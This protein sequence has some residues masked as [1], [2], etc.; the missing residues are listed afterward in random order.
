MA[1]YRCI[2][3]PPALQKNRRRRNVTR[4]TVAAVYGLF[5]GTDISV[6]PACSARI[7]T[8]SARMCHAEKARRAAGKG[9]VEKVLRQTV[10][11]HDI[12]VIIGTGDAVTNDANDPFAGLVSGITSAIRNGEAKNLLNFTLDGEVLGYNKAEDGTTEAEPNRKYTIDINVDINPFDLLDIVY[13]LGKDGDSITFDMSK[14]ELLTLIEGLGYF[15]LTINEVNVEDDSLVKNIITIHSNFSEG[16]AIAAINLPSLSV[17]VVNANLQLGGVYNFE[18]LYDVIAGLI[19]SSSSGSAAENATAASD[20]INISEILESIISCIDF[21]NMAADGITID[22]DGLVDT[23][24]DALLSG[25][26]M[27]P[28]LSTALKELIGSDVL[29][30][31][32]SATFQGCTEDKKVV[33][34]DLISWIATNVKDEE[35]EDTTYEQGKYIVEVTAMDEGAAF[36]DDGNAED[37]VIKYPEGQL[38]GF[39]RYDNS[40]RKIPLVGKTLD[41]EEIHFY[42]YIVG[43]NMPG[44]LY[45]EAGVYENP[46]FYIGLSNGFDGTIDALQLASILNIEQGWPVSGVIPFQYQ[47]T[48]EIVAL[49]ENATVTNTLD[50]QVYTENLTV[51]SNAFTGVVGGGTAVIT[52]TIVDEENDLDW[53]NELKTSGYAVFDAEG[54]NV[55]DSAITVNEGLVPALS[56]YTWAESGEFTVVIYAGAVSFEYQVTVAEA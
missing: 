42:G 11:M 38:F 50:N 25:S 19:K 44:G 14:D 15:N 55:T 6:P 7:L 52:I 31:K 21:E 3:N 49:S 13:A 24:I 29:N 26:D 1:A 28:T 34:T 43:T 53:S 56:R 36:P 10:N 4:V 41:G 40:A 35:G 22:A 37:G 30:V 20:G 27:G 46:V 5:G 45:P 54:N 39:A 23:L 51:G 8:F 48:V 32:A 2:Q 47:G 16:M 33:T 12:S 17:S 18:G 9:L